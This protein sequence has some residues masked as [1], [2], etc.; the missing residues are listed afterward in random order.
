[1]NKDNAH[2][3]LP[4]V[5]AL[6]EGKTIQVATMLGWLDLECCDFSHPVELCRIKPEPL[7]YFVNIYADEFPCIAYKTRFAATSGAISKPIRIVRMIE[8]EGGEA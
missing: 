6:A 2:L 1:M 8:A 4:L 3:Y 5:Q 7:V